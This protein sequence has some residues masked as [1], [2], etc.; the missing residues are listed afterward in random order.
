MLNIV[1]ALCSNSGCCG[2]NAL[3]TFSLIFI[4]IF[5]ET[6][7]GSAELAAGR[8]P[9]LSPCGAARIQEKAVGPKQILQGAGKAQ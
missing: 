9:L 7:N 6:E 8:K 1:G 5:W 4:F 3:M 2:Q